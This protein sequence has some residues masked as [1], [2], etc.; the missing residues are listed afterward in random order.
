MMPNPTL[1]EGA[2]TWA[3]LRGL[4]VPSRGS[5]AWAG[6]FRAWQRSLATSALPRHPLG[7]PNRSARRSGYEAEG[8][9]GLSVG[10]VEAGALVSRTAA[11][12]LQ[13]LG[14]SFSGGKAFTR[15]E[16]ANEAAGV[17]RGASGQHL[18]PGSVGVRVGHALS[19]LERRGYV[20][21]IGKEL[22]HTGRPGPMRFTLTTVG[23]DR[24]LAGQ[25]AESFAFGEQAVER[26]IARME[27]LPPPPSGP[28]SGPLYRPSLPVL[29]TKGHKL[30]KLQGARIKTAGYRTCNPRRKPEQHP[31][32]AMTAKQ[33][34]EMSERLSFRPLPALL[35]ELAHLKSQHALLRSLG[36]PSEAMTAMERI[37]KD[38]VAFAKKRSKPNPTGSPLSGLHTTAKGE[39][40]ILYRPKLAHGARPR[41]HISPEHEAVLLQQDAEEMRLAFGRS[42]D[43]RA[44]NAPRHGYSERSRAFLEAKIPLLISEGYPHA[45]AVAIAL[46][47]ARRSGMKV[48]ARANPL[49]GR[50]ADIVLDRAFRELSTLT[51][52][53][54]HAGRLESGATAYEDS[55][56][57]M[58]LGPKRMHDQA[59]RMQADAA[60]VL[61]SAQDA[62]AAQRAAAPPTSFPARNPLTA[63]EVH[64]L[65]ARAADAAHRARESSGPHGL[66]DAGRA[67]GYALS[68]IDGSLDSPADAWGLATRRGGKILK[69]AKASQQR[70]VREVAVNPFE[71]VRHALPAPAGRAGLVFATVTGKADRAL[72]LRYGVD[73]GRGRFGFTPELWAALIA[74]KTAGRRSPNPL[75]VLVLGNSPHAA[76]RIH[77][78][79][80]LGDAAQE[81]G[82][83]G[84]GSPRASGLAARPRAAN[85]LPGSES[86]RAPPPGTP[87]VAEVRA[88]VLEFHGTPGARWV[89]HDLDDGKPGITHK[90]VAAL[91]VTEAT[92]YSAPWRASN[93]HEA[94]VYEH[95]HERKK[96][97]E[98]YDPVAHATLKLLKGGSGPSDWWRD[99]R[100]PARRKA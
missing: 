20:Q 4:P 90:A 9:S 80:R 26:E 55:A 94:G 88:H 24:A 72:A 43:M 70:L 15:D 6:L 16:L 69:S 41:L 35:S 12:V 36:R 13:A 96:P 50:E 71:V 25:A 21:R 46:D 1:A 56:I 7:T 85:H 83:P 45:Q 37:V 93:K 67:F 48:P 38:A 86:G 79:R 23:E 99:D 68:A 100:G 98:V 22:A 10:D 44:P 19:E 27:S 82:S 61:F 39:E 54:S 11:P 91:G 59:A 87:G 65:L 49:T 33:R 58:Q 47:M 42:D 84:L 66:V 2:E 62:I 28:L 5:P 63:P 32:L 31:A 64:G 77:A 57:V 29:E 73:H 81:P 8:Y 92:V 18:S 51:P 17:L 34:S 3:R 74:E 89:T 60:R 40:F 97:L 14:S 76:S 52:G 95:L 75:S 30:P 53:T 78:P